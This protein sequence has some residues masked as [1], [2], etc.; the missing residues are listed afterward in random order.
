MKINNRNMTKLLEILATTAA[1]LFWLPVL[2]LV[3]LTHPSLSTGSKYGAL[4][5][6]AYF[7]IYTLQDLW[8]TKTGA[9]R[10]DWQ[11][12]EREE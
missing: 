9:E 5:C 11:D 6:G 10:Y 4:F 3:L 2:G 12:P 7:S 8:R 1:A